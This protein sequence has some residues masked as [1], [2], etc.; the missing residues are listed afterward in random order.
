[1]KPVTKISR[2]AF[3]SQVQKCKSYVSYLQLKLI[4]TYIVSIIFLFKYESIIMNTYSLINQFLHVRFGLRR[5]V[6]N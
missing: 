6:V 3:L 1:M 4:G 2:A 5:A